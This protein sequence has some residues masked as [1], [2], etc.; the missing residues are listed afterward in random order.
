MVFE[1]FIK[2]KNAHYQF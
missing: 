2:M 1:T